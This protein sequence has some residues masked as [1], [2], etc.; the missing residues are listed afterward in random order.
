MLP[1]QDCGWEPPPGGLWPSLGG[2]AVRWIQENLITPEGDTFGQPFKLRE[3]QRLFLFRWYEYCGGCEHWRFDEGVRGAATGDGKTT[4]I[5]AI[6]LLEFAGPPAIVPN[7]PIVNIAAA[8]FDQANELFRKAGQMVG[9]RD[10]EITEAPLCGFFQVY[11]TEIRFRDGRP[12]VMKRV[13]AAAGTN[14]GGLP[15]LF[16][17]DEV[18]EWGEVGSNKARVHTVIGKSTK[19]RNT[20]RGPG[21]ILDLSTAGFDV[22]NSL[23]GAMYKRGKR[24]LHDPRT[25]PKLLFDWQEAPDGLDYD[26][27]ADRR[28]AVKA[29]SQAAGVLWNVE[30]RV[31]DWGRPDMARHEWIRYFANRWVEM[32][33]DSWLKDHPTAWAE[34]EGNASIP[35]KADVVVAVDMALKRDSVAVVTAWQR[36]DGRVAVQ[37]KIWKPEGDKIDHLEVVD[38]IRHD[39]ADEYTITEIAYDPRFFEVPARLLEEEGFNLHEFPQSP[40][41]MTPACG[42]ARVA[43]LSKQVVHNGDPDLAEHVNTA[44]ERP[45]ERGFTLSKS[46]SWTKKKKIDACIALVIALWRVFAPDEEEDELVPWVGSVA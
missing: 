35:H 18:H 9:G 7:S 30:D 42:E 31:R 11:D 8:K 46:K 3:D 15:H 27:P 37:A 12:G 28:I 14:E 4:F 21:R 38:Y 6:G 45:N 23:L 16:I 26:S 17:A 20:H 44:A 1:C 41:R 19:K 5:A 29:A 36:P 2:L 32:A 13:A 43:I 22:D 33:E 24:A 34:C 39:L 10:D 25:A 40:E